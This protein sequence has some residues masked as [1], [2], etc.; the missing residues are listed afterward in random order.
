MEQRTPEW[1]AARLGRVTSSKITDAM[2]AKTTAGYRNYRAQLVAERLTGIVADTYCSFDMQQGIER[3]PAA[4]LC[5]QFKTG[6]KIEEVGFMEHAS[7][8]SG[9][10]P[11][12]LVHKDGMIEIKCVKVATHL[13]YLTGGIVPKKH[14]PQMHHQM[15][16]TG[17]KWNDFVS[18]CPELP[19]NLQLFI[20]RLDRDEEEIKLMESKI[21]AFENDIQD[22]LKSLESLAQ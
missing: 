2:M 18:Y 14:R 9:S 12:G 4:R 21:E 6:N 11:D 16:C 15:C 3:E 5:Y 22:M 10:S 13:D 19:E 1:Y 7:L 8:F 17:R 20:C